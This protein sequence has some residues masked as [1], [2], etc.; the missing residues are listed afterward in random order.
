V[1]L[2]FAGTILYLGT[3]IYLWRYLR[4]HHRST[5]EWLGCPNI[6]A[7]DLR[8][9]QWSLYSIWLIFSGRYATLQDPRVA[10]TVWL[11]RAEFAAVMGLIVFGKLNG[12][13]PAQH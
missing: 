9:M 3:I 13:I 4:D 7:P 8:A 11:I 2:I 6:L 1:W 10:R 5:W 12:L